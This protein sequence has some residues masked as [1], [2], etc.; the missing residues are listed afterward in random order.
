LRD[1]R[2]RRPR[3]PAPYTEQLRVGYAGG[4][5]LRH[6][7]DG[8]VYR[9]RFGHD[10]ENWALFEPFNMRPEP[11][12][13]IELSDPDLAQALAI[14]HLDIDAA[15]AAEPIILTLRIATERTLSTGEERQGLNDAP[16]TAI[17]HRRGRDCVK[18]I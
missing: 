13:P 16:L 1:A 12:L 2:N 9:S 10:T 18:K 17:S 6:G 14:Y 15:G 4:V 5:A 7:F 3:W 8:T 11:S